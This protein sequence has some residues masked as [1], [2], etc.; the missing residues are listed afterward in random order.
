[1]VRV[2]RN[3]HVVD[4]IKYNG[5]KYGMLSKPVRLRLRDN[6]ELPLTRVDEDRM[7]S[8]VGVACCENCVLIE[9]NVS[10]KNSGKKRAVMSVSLLFFTDR[11]RKIALGDL[12]TEEGESTVH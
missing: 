4:V 7:V 2:P 5:A 9:D 8:V 6:S 12:P 3:N 11:S 1:M 10:R